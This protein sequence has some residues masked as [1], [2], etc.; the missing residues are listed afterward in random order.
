[1]SRRRWT[2]VLHKPP[3]SPTLIS[4]PSSSAPRRRPYIRGLTYASLTVCIFPC[5]LR[6][7]G[8]IASPTSRF[9]EQFSSISLVFLS[10]FTTPSK[11]TDLFLKGS[12]HIVNSTVDARY[13]GWLLYGISGEYVDLLS[14]KPFQACGYF[15]SILSL[16]SSGLLVP[17]GKG[18]LP[19]TP[20]CLPCHCCAVNDDLVSLPDLASS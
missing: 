18:I 10:C 20:S 15:R 3:R 12:G 1:M 2:K 16:G 8:S 9:S 11:P 7:L 17:T 4:Q 6:R 14:G 13:N 19:Q 5:I